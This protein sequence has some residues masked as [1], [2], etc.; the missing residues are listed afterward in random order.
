MR[1]TRLRKDG[2]SVML[3]PPGTLPVFLTGE[4]AAS[5]G[6]RHKAAGSDR[7][8]QRDGLGHGDGLELVGEIGGTVVL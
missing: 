8:H 4:L 2:G 7:V 1:I 6:L 5:A 3:A